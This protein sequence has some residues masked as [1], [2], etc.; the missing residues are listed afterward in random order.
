MAFSYQ[1]M[2]VSYQKGYFSYHLPLA[3]R[4]GPHHFQWVTYATEQ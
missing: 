3:L 4:P 1:E 2:L